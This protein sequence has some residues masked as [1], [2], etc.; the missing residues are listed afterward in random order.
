[1]MMESDEPVQAPLNEENDATV[2]CG[3][4]NEEHKLPDGS[5]GEDADDTDEAASSG[6]TVLASPLV[7]VTS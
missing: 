4:K 3:G 6:E 1:M 2:V 5:V 7:T